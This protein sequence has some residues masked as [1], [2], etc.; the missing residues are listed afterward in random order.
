MNDEQ[1]AQAKAY[2]EQMRASGQPDDVIINNLMGQGWPENAI[3]ELFPIDAPLPESVVDTH[4]EWPE[5]RDQP[6]KLPSSP[7]KIIPV[8]IVATLLMLGIGFGAGYFAG[9]SVGD[10]NSTTETSNEAKLSTFSD[11]NFTIDLLDSWEGDAG[12]EAGSEVVMFYS[13][14]YAIKQLATQSA[15]MIIYVYDKKEAGRIKQQLESL[16][17]AGGKYEIVKEE[18]VNFGDQK[19]KLVDFT[20]SSKEQP[21][22]KRRA[23]MIEVDGAEKSYDIS[24]SG[25]D[26]SWDRHSAN[27]E[28]MLKSF[29][30][31]K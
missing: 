9:K 1:K 3:L 14:E 12:Y 30:P 16:T 19:G 6:A 17:T 24:V 11:P 26:E 31:L 28:R 15:S 5:Q 22:K 8:F 13:P 4:K 25:L 2:I 27:V 29:K 23:A 18:E 20:F 7:A 10:A 21:D